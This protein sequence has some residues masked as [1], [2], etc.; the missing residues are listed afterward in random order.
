MAIGI[1]TVK[2]QMSVMC[3]E[4]LIKVCLTLSLLAATFVIC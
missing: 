2:E 4:D 3:F 1:M